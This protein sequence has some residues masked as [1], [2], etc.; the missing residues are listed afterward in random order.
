MTDDVSGKVQSLVNA[1]IWVDIILTHGSIESAIMG[2]AA[3]S[4]VRST[5]RP[6]RTYARAYFLIG[7]ARVPVIRP[8]LVHLPALGLRVGTSIQRWN[9]GHVPYV[10]G[11]KRVSLPS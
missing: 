1:P 10:Q 8:F 4:T 5:I 7:V 9:H 3:L 6:K 2:P 11:Q